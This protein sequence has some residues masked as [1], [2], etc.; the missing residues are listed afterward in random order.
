M[1]LIPYAPLYSLIL[2]YNL[3]LVSL[4]YIFDTSSCVFNDRM[5]V[6]HH[7]AKDFITS[8]SL[9]QSPQIPRVD[10]LIL[11]TQS[12]SRISCRISYIKF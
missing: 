4:G 11:T 8:H 3:K 7:L 12:S 10:D 9:N 6:Y 5:I 2:D 1:D